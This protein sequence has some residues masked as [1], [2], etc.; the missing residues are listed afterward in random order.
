MPRRIRLPPDFAELLAEFG[1]ADVSYL[2]VGG[3]AVGF[4]DRPRTTKDLDLL[5]G[6]DSANVR[7][8]CRAL[9]RLFAAIEL[10]PD[11]GHRCQH[12]EVRAGPA[13]SPVRSAGA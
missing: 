1:A 12:P 9:E 3:Y 13:A 11:A 5:V 10:A 2:M 8:A 6:A 4:H 7:R